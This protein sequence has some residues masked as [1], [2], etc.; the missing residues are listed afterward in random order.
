MGLSTTALTQ[1]IPLP[2]KNLVRASKAMV[3]SCGPWLS[4]CLLES[5]PEVEIESFSLSLSP[6]VSDR[7]CRTI[8]FL[9]WVLPGLGIGGHCGDKGKFQEGRAFMLLCRPLLLWHIVGARR[10]NKR[11][12]L[13]SKPPSRAGCLT[14]LAL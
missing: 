13:L 8:F 2:W 9:L 5:G 1:P 11:I 4:V 14:S 3:S 12:T 7:K 10:M 6:C